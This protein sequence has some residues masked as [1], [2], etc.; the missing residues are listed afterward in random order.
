MTADADKLRIVT[1]MSSREQRA[2]I[3]RHKVECYILN[4]KRQSERWNV[5][6]SSNFCPVNWDDLFCWDLTRAGTVARKSCPDYINGFNKNAYATKVCM[7]N[8]SWWV[9]PEHNQTWTNY[10]ECVRTSIDL[11]FHTA[12]GASLRLL[13]TIG[14]SFSLGS[15][16]VALI[17]MLCCKRLHS[18]SNTLHVN[19]FLAFIFRAVISFLKDILFVQN[20]GLAKDVRRGDDG[21]LEFVPDNPHW[22]CKLIMSIFMYSVNACNMWIFAEALY[23]TMLVSRPLATE[24]GG[25]RIYIIL[26]WCKYVCA[27]RWMFVPAD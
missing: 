15:L 8:G 10:T 24:R 19:L 1:V 2:N 17:I 26:G 16:L 6:D 7:D 3:L 4:E 20:V 12:H 22:E 18:K 13:Y 14:Y 25:V 23:L 21:I 9:N 5:T 11:S 27:N